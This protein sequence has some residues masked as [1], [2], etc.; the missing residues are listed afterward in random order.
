MKLYFLGSAPSLH[1]DL[2]DFHSNLL[3]ETASKKRLLINCGADI[4]YSLKSLNDNGLLID[5]LYISEIGIATSRG[6]EW[7]GFLNKFTPN[8]QK[9]TLYLNPQLAKPLWDN[10]LSGVGRP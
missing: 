9:P 7:M 6:L 3:L 2:S 4:R 5:A 1:H 8:N 10:S